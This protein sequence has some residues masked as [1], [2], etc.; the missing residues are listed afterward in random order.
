MTSRE[1][2]M[3][4]VTEN[5]QLG[6]QEWDLVKTAGKGI[7]IVMHKKSIDEL[8]VYSMSS[9]TETHPFDDDGMAKVRRYNAD[10][11]IAL[12]S[13]KTGRKLK[14]RDIYAIEGIVG[15]KSY[16]DPVMAIKDFINQNEDIEFDPVFEEVVEED[17][18]GDCD[19]DN[20]DCEA[21]TPTQDEI[22]LQILAMLNK[23]MDK[24]DK[25]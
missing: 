23:I 13:E 12:Y 20:C 2:R 4:L 7:G 19:C 6:L 9:V 25:N 16:A 14:N 5:N 17:V 8:V 18:C 22:N 1:M 3:E 15:I 10:G 21:P 24:L 11:T